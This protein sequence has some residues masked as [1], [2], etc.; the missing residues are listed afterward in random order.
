MERCSN[1]IFLFN[2][3]QYCKM[4]KA[5][6]FYKSYYDVASELNDKDRLQFYDALIKKQFTGIDTELKGMAYFAYISQKHNID[7]QVAGYEFKTKLK[8]NDNVG[9]SVVGSVGGSVQEK[10]EE[11]EK[12]KEKGEYTQINAKTWRDDFQLYKDSLS[13]AYDNCK[14][15]TV[16]LQKPK[17]PKQISIKKDFETRK[18]DFI[19]SLSKYKNE[20][21]KEILNQFFR[22]WSE[23]N[24]QKDTMRFEDQKYF[25]ISKRLITWKRNANKNEKE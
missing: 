7:S 4:R 3:L 9:G 11:K 17:T 15:N 16:L 23:K 6:N 5:F 10:G 21:S 14:N 24:T 1:N 2:N 12:E 20:Y 19:E 8:L 18:N 13:T 25:E 22:Y